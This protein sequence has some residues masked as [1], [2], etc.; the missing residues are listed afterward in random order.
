MYDFDIE[1]LMGMIGET[2]FGAVFAVLV[3][4][5][6]LA[7]AVAAVFY[8]LQ[9]V[10]LYSI[11]DRRG[12]KNPWLAWVPVGCNWIMG[13]ISDQYRYVARGEVRNK[14]KA[15]LTLN[16]IM[17]VLEVAVWIF[18]LYMTIRFGGAVAVGAYGAVAALSAVF[19]LT[20]LVTAG[21]SIAVAVISYIA[22][23]DLFRSCEPRN[24]GLYL[25]LSI[26]LSWI[27]PILLMVVRKKD[28][29]MPP[30][31]VD[32]E[33]PQDPVEPQQEAPQDAPV[34]SEE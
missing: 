20:S 31:R 12:I 15:L 6:L 16:I 30:K 10:S 5:M 22:L 19:T 28:G 4:V 1:S 34:Q 21:I 25:V 26:L 23:Y 33:A 3:V 7:L 8:V 29:G 24:A 13:C 2:M 17:V 9:A 32:A 14:R 18:D 11:A 27:M